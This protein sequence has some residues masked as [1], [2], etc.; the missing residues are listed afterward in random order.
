MN[1]KRSGDLVHLRAKWAGTLPAC[2]RT[3]NISLACGIPM[4]LIV[5]QAC[6]MPILALIVVPV[7]W[8]LLPVAVPALDSIDVKFWLSYSYSLTHSSQDELAL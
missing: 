6:G 1:L 2:V 4:L 7:L 5:V 3:L 8:V